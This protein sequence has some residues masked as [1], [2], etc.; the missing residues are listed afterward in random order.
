MG[1][2]KSFDDF[3]EAQ[4][5]RIFRAAYAVSGDRELAA[6]ATQEAFTRALVRWRRVC[7][8]PSPEGWVMTTA[9]NEVKRQLKKHK[10]HMPLEASPQISNM[11]SSTD[12]VGVAQALAGLRPRQQQAAVLFYIGDM[13]IKAVAEVMSISEGAVK[14]HLAQARTKLE[15]L[16]EVNHA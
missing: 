3:Y 5:A 4:F 2:A 12:R 9:L 8:H 7:R 13:E 11:E 1:V 15:Q 14:A 6:E 10:R 16:L